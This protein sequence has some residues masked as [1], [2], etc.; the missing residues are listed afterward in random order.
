MAPMDIYRGELQCL[1]RHRLAVIF[2]TIMAAMALFILSD[3]LLSPQRFGELLGF[4]LQFLVVGRNV[5]ALPSNPRLNDPVKFLLRRRGLERFLDGLFGVFSRV[6]GNVIRHRCIHPF[7]ACR[8]SLLGRTYGVRNRF[9]GELRKYYL[10]SRDLRISA[11]IIFWDA[12][13]SP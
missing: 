8:L 2:A 10:T 11:R 5:F 1:H 7:R 9:A 6:S 3:Y 12:A 13:W 4:R